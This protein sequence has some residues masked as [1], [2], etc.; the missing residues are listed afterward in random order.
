M[1]EIAALAVV[2]I[3]ILNLVVA[4]ALTW[5]RHPRDGWLP[6]ILLGGTSMIAVVAV[7][8]MLLPETALNRDRGIDVALVVAFMAAVVAVVPAVL[9]RAVAK[10][11]A[12]DQ[13]PPR[14]S[15][16]AQDPEAAP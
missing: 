13:A 4:S 10:Q 2:V 6:V 8:T 1:V 5:R 14:E 11:D 15:G 7:G 16:P 9:A 12:A 3:L